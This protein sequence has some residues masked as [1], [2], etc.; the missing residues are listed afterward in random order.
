MFLAEAI[1]LKVLLEERVARGT[2]APAFALDLLERMSAGAS[3]D[4]EARRALVDPLTDRERT[5][6][7]Y[8]T[9]S[10]RIPRSRPAIHLNQHAEDP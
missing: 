7:R 10:S 3:T 9:G 5:V 6:L 2:V 8:L 4:L 1:R